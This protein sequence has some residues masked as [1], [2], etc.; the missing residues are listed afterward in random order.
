MIGYL[1]PDQVNLPHES[2]KITEIDDKAVLFRSTFPDDVII[3]VVD[4]K[5]EKVL[6]SR[7]KISR[8]CSKRERVNM[9]NP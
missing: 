9:V 3:T 7:R 6:I 8:V 2:L 1:P 4:L 5:K